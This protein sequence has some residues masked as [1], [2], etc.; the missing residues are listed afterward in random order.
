VRIVST[1]TQPY[2]DLIY[3]PLEGKHLVGEHVEEIKKWVGWADAVVI[4]PGLGEQSH[5]VVQAIA[6]CCKAVVYDADALR[7]P[8]PAS[9]NAVYTPH[10][11]EFA[12][13]TGK[14]PP[15]ELISRARAVKDAGIPGVVLLK[16]PVDVI[17]DGSRVRFN[18]TGSPAMAVAGTGDVL[19]GVTGALLC[20]LPPFEAACVAAYINGRAGMAASETRGD[21]ML[22]SD[23]LD[24]IP[25]QLWRSR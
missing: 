5:P 15:D 14:R 1:V 17:S 12:R 20:R 3:V 19:A 23:L 22:A 21:G 18:R 7:Q 16:G 10:T 2:P 6:P 4:G 11:G 25:R 13:I 8:L 24:E 9:T